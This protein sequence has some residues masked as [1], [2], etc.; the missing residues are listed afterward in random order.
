MQRISFK[1]REGLSVRFELLTVLGIFGLSLFLAYFGPLVYHYPI[2]PGD[3]IYV[4]L[5]NITAIVQHGL[6]S[7]GS[8]Y[9][10]GFYL[11]V[12][13]LAK[14]TGITTIQSLTYIAPLLLPLSGIAIWWFA[15]SLVDKKVAL[16]AY[17]LYALIS[18]QPLQTYYDGSLPNL[19][20]AGIILPLLFFA[21]LKVFQEKQLRWGI[22]LLTLTII[23]ILSHH[24]TVLVFVAVACLWLIIWVFWQLSKDKRMKE[25]GL[26]IVGI[27]VFI[28]LFIWSFAHLTIFE[29]AYGVFRTYL[30]VIP[31]F[32]YLISTHLASS[33]TWTIQTYGE[34]LS[35]FIFQ[36][37]FVG[38]V[39]L[40]FW[41]KLADKTRA[42]A[43]LLSIWFFVYFIGSVSSWAGEPT[44]LA[45]DLA[46]PA[47][48]LA[49][50]ITWQ[51]LQLLYKQN[52]TLSLFLVWLLIP[53]SIIGFYH[54]AG[55][56]LAETPLV[57]FSQADQEAYS[58]LLDNQL[59]PQTTVVLDDASWQVVV[60]A[61]GTNRLI[62]YITPRVPYDQ[63]RKTPCYLIGWY[64][65]DVWQP[66]V[67]DPSIAQSYFNRPELITKAEFND[68]Y[69]V[70]YILCAK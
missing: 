53:L 30:Q 2:A 56:A 35:G 21:L 6:P 8:S 20:T 31:H 54:K 57:R 32:P 39:L 23:L 55:Y 29:P 40:P 48:I 36:A 69:R 34:N 66:L 44:R 47:S 43:L 45:R 65:E 46:M 63:I 19:L 50:W 38:A 13:A 27:V 41:P 9:P 15:R 68:S 52:Q 16:L 22:A 59:G 61:R 5:S 37:G 42:V 70:R 33:P 26:F 67:P 18:L 11:L 24:L 4:H 12:I 14:L 58:Y 64:V 51:F 1:L 10:Y 62:P 60:A 49:G 28:P 7:L 17:G 3:D 25:L